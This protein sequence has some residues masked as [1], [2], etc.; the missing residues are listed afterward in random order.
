MS[1]EEKKAVEEA[2]KAAAQQKAVEEEAKNAATLQLEA[3]L[4][5]KDAEIVKLSEERNNY[6][7]GMLKAK[8]KIDDI[9]DTEESIDEKID[10]KVQERLLDSQFIK[11]QKDKEDIIKQVLA[12][13]KELETAIKNRS[14]ISSAGMGSS[15][16]EK[17]IAKDNILTDEHLKALKGKGWDDKK[18]A[19]YK[20]NLVKLK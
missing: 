10:R 1:D 20:Q 4:A 15:S 3:Q 13:N 14:Q 2:E 16:D 11:A 18:I 5:E 19:L 17:L 9:D 7:K 12:R 8:G 6:K